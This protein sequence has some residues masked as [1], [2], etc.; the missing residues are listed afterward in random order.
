MENKNDEKEIL[1]VLEF[2]TS[3][4]DSLD[5]KTRKSP[6]GDFLLKTIESGENKY[7]NKIIQESKVF[8]VDY[9]DVF[10]TAYMHLERITSDPKSGIKYLDEVVKV[11]KARKI[12]SDTI[13]HL[14]SHT[15]YIRE[16]KNDGAVIPS[17][18]LTSFAEEDLAIYENRFIKTLLDRVEVFLRLRYDIIKDNLESY[19]RNIFK[20]NSNFQIGDRDVS[21][22]LDVGI[23]KEIPESVMAAKEAY[24]KISELRNLFKSLKNSPFIRSI[25]DSRPV[26]PPI[27]KTNIILHNPDFKVAYNLW[28]FLDRYDTQDYDTHAN[29]FSQEYTKNAKDDMNNIVASLVASVMFH[30]KFID[31]DK[32]SMEF[33][34]HVK[35]YEKMPFE[36]ED[37][38][39]KPG[40]YTLLDN[41]VNEYYLSKINEIYA[42]KMKEYSAEGQSK[43]VSFRKVYKDIL[44]TLNS[45]Y[46]ELYEVY[47]A[48][49][50][51]ELSL[52]EQLENAKKR[53]KVTKIVNKLKEQDLVRT[54]KEELKYL[55]KIEKLKVRIQKKK[56]RELKKKK[57]TRNK[58]S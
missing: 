12:N 16:V 24:A 25:K 17:K 40:S 58:K 1:S 11:E 19:E 42:D 31:F 57:K 44:K 39:L 21:V 50:E 4:K 28:L 34:S 37:L 3:I 56:E 55:T 2:Y 7:S 36:Q 10:Q 27:M 6:F 15:Q 22:S 47:P 13:R 14:S 30:Q 33:N 23:K 43:S 53:V 46:P 41:T 29:E 5:I 52:E 9:I 18:L 54:Q 49:E 35:E 32:A 20:T 48:S 26:V 38:T 8:K 51:R 45:V